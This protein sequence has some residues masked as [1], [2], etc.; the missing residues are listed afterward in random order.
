MGGWNTIVSFLGQ[1][2]YFQGA[3]AV[4]FRDCIPASSKGCLLKHPL[5]DSVQM[6]FM[7]RLYILYIIQ[8]I[9]LWKGR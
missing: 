2:A 6:Q 4:S 5:E 7:A 9:V 1:K 3:F 8:L